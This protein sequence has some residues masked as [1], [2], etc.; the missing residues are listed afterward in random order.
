MR[1]SLFIVLTFL[2]F[3]G[4]GQTNSVRPAAS[5]FLNTP[6]SSDGDSIYTIVEVQP[7]YPGGTNA[8]LKFLAK[9]MKYPASARKKGIQGRVFVGFIVGADGK[10]ENAQIV[11]GVDA[12]LDSE[13][14]R[15][16]R[17]FPAWK[18]GTQDGKPVRV[19]YV[20]PINFLL[21]GKK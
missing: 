11:K 13:A 14:E 3:E 7:E 19:R 5:S 8:M 6:R 15:V 2:T 20:I 4:M 9:N 12:T 16:I 1:Y 17:L 21:P 10:I 18:P